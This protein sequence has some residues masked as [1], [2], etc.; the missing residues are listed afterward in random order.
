MCGDGPGIAVEG[1]LCENAER[2]CHGEKQYWLPSVCVG[3]AWGSARLYAGGTDMRG[4]GREQ[5]D[6][7]VALAARAAA[8]GAAGRQ[9]VLLQG[10][11]ELLLAAGLG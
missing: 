6:R 3:A 11:G 7:D 1:Q 4:D 5:L 9:R 2:G 8:G 10:A